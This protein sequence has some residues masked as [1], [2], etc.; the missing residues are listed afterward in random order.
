MQSSH[1]RYFCFFKH[2][3]SLTISSVLEITFHGRDFK[4]GKDLSNLIEMKIDTQKYHYFVI[5]R[6]VH[7]KIG[8][9][10]FVDSASHFF[11]I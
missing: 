7:P 3:I 4:I 9:G 11:K 6:F 5:L 8:Q 10:C 1:Q 2:G